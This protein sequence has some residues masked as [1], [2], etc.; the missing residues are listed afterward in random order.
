MG[1]VSREMELLRKNQKEVLGRK[2]NTET[3][4]KNDFDGLVSRSNVAEQSRAEFSAVT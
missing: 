2:K 3:E 4:M 1:K